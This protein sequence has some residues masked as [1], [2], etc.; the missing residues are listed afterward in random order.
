MP[1][2][3]LTGEEIQKLQKKI[4]EISSLI[5][6]LQSKTAEQIYLQELKELAL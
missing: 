1:I 2:Y 3:T 6:S 4:D 5:K